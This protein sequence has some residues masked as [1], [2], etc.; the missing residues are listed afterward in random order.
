[1]RNSMRL[2]AVCVVLVVG[3]WVL[4]PQ[5]SQLEGPG[6]GD[7]AETTGEAVISDAE[8]AGQNGEE[9]VV[10]KTSPRTQS[11]DLQS[12]PATA[13]TPSKI[14]DLAQNPG[15]TV[16]ALLDAALA[17]D[18]Q[19]QRDIISAY[20]TCEQATLVMGG[21]VPPDSAGTTIQ[22]NWLAAS[23]RVSAACASFLNGDINVTEL[24]QNTES[25]LRSA[26]P[27]SVTLMEE[28]F[29]RTLAGH[30][31]LLPEHV[32]TPES[33]QA[34]I[35]QALLE[36]LRTGDRVFLNASPEILGR[37][38]STDL[39]S[40]AK[41]PGWDRP[42]FEYHMMHNMAWNIAICDVY[43]ACDASGGSLAVDTVCL[44]DWSRC[45][46][47]SGSLA[48]LI[49]DGN[50]PPAMAPTLSRLYEWYIMHMGSGSEDQLFG[51][52]G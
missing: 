8:S 15:A 5:A 49:L 25:W 24:K 10:S 28:I 36:A 32:A 42:E 17:G 19:A 37:L 29:G 52:G 34:Y 14:R 12:K 51:D 22:A 20:K 23:D 39:L 21:D 4:F 38:L 40:L 35:E 11:D 13:S 50:L 45:G 3:V 46:G 16:L 6:V 30:P 44:Q 48:D 1:M 47:Q 7:A 18:V 31:E 2:G 9:P 33:A 43:Q 27:E 41:P 26:K